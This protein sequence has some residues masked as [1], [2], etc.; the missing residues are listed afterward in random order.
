MNTTNAWNIFGKF[1]F[2]RKSAKRGN[3][4][5]THFGVN[6]GKNLLSQLA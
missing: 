2:D 3:S 1:R 6:S 5:L 4:T